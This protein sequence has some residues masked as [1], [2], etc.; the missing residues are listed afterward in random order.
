MDLLD[1]IGAAAIIN[2][3]ARTRPQV[4]LAEPADARA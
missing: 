2:H 4:H 1:A 3:D